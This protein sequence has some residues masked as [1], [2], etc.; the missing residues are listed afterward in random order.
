MKIVDKILVDPITRGLKFFTKGGVVVSQSPVGMSDQLATQLGLKQYLHG[1]TY[2]GGNAPTITLSG[3]AGSFANG[4]VGK[5]IP[6]QTQDGGWRMKF[7]LFAGPST[8]IGISGST[9]NVQVNG[10]TSKNLVNQAVAASADGVTNIMNWAYMPPNTGN[11]TL[12]FSTS[13]NYNQTSYVV[14]GDVELDS[15][16]TW[17][18]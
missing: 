18:Y 12:H 8:T 13:N 5:F 2:N 14:G 17:A 9:F 1:T 10:V 4:L 15:K 3:Y 7:N 16:P 6:Y 11:I